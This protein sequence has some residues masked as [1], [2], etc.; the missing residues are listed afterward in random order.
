MLSGVTI[1]SDV[2]LDG[3]IQRRKIGFV[4][5]CFVQQFI[6]RSGG[7]SGQELAMRV[8]PQIFAAGAQK[9]RARRNQ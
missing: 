1:E 6:D 3:M 9:Q 5:A 8:A 7:A 2:V 4:N